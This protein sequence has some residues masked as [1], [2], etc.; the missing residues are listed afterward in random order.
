MHRREVSDDVLEKLADYKV[1]IMGEYHNIAEHTA[2]MGQLSTAL[3]KDYGFFNFL[4]ETPQAFSWMYED[5]SMGLIP[6][7]DDKTA[8]NFWFHTNEIERIRNYNLTQPLEK[9]IKVSTIDINHSPY[10]YVMS[11]QYMFDYIGESTYLREY[12]IYLRSIIENNEE[13]IN[14]VVKFKEELFSK[15]GYVY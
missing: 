2:L 15:K 12:S 14:T 13:Y 5:Y 1:V 7:V 9:R 3:N 6:E 8:Y 10:S 11:I 4:I